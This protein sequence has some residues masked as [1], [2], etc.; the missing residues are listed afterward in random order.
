MLQLLMFSYFSLSLE[1]RICETK[2]CC[3]N[4]FLKCFRHIFTTIMAILVAFFFS[5]FSLNTF[6]CFCFV[7]RFNQSC[8][9]FRSFHICFWCRCRLQKPKK[10]KE[11]N[12]IHSTASSSL[13]RVCL[14]VT[15]FGSFGICFIGIQLRFLLCLWHF[16]FYLTLCYVDSQRKTASSLPLHFETNIVSFDAIDGNINFFVINGVQTTLICHNFLDSFE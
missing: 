13:R 14:I 6:C 11:N 16:L 10:A 5:F 9:N 1:L 12:R 4:S 3:H 7:S 2:F 8:I 15:K